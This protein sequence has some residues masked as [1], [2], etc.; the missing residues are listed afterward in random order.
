MA[1]IKPF[2][3]LRPV[4]EKASSVSSIPYDVVH[5]EAEVRKFIASNPLSSV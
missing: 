4:S 2:R 5:D 1:K 3:A